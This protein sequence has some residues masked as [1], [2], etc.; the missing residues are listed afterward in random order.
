MKTILIIVGG[1]ADAS[2]RFVG[3]ETPL[4]AA[5]KPELDTLARL[6]CAGSLLTMNGDVA[7]T[8]ENALLSILGYDFFRGIPDAANLRAF[9]SG[10]PFNQNDIRFFVV[11]KFSGHGVV[12][13]DNPEVR[14]AAMMAMLRPLF[15]AG[16]DLSITPDHPCGSLSDKARTTIK[17]IAIFDF[18]LVYAGEA[19][20]A[21]RRRDFDAKKEAISKISKDLI[22]PVADYV[23]NAKLQ[24]N[25]V[26]MSDRI[27]SCQTG[28][29]LPGEVPAVVYFNDDLPYDL[30]TFS[31]KSVE[32][33]PLIAPKPG[34][35]IR[36]LI[37]FE[38]SID[39]EH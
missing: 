12:I 9:G 13:S 7:H 36:Q 18:V 3:G 4:M 35:L 38:T 28:A 31:E 6:G 15:P 37:S 34:D 24:M 27:M 33:G 21:S 11:P 26:V 25:L 5:E 1:M 2:Q 29:P 16:E 10:L 19:E 17:A 23:W 8:P 32:D 22:G 39:A 14:G 30:E 20:E